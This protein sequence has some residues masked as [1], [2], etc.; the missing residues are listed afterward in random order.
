MA[1]P[2]TL[3]SDWVH[4]SEWCK[5]QDLVALPAERATVA[6]YI[7]YMADRGYKVATI[8]RRLLGISMRHQKA[9]QPDPTKA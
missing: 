3:R 8:E 2:R 6:A 1:T 7:A 9:G 4:F 5:Q